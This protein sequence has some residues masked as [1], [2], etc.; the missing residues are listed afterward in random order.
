MPPS[1]PPA[2]AK[3]SD[4]PPPSITPLP[5]SSP[6]ST[7]PPAP[8]PK[9]EPPKQMAPVVVIPAPLPFQVATPEP[10][11]SPL[12]PTVSSE[13]P[14]L[15]A[16][17]LE[18]AAVEPASVPGLE[19]KIVDDEESDVEVQAHPFQ[20]RGLLG[21]LQ[22]MSE[23]I[24]PRILQKMLP[25]TRER[26]RHL[27]KYVKGVVAVCAAVCVLAGVS[28]AI[29]SSETGEAKAAPSRTVAI[30]MDQ[31]NGLARLDLV[32]AAPA[33]EAKAEKADKR[34]AAAAKP[35]KRR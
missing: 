18:V 12:A 35:A 27:A 2:V 31:R 34:V 17:P 22:T 28:A 1:P 21:T 14:M 19:R 7:P 30:L 25:A 16:P 33:P 24:D 13:T 8:A 20:R 6:L 23:V 9:S 26:R 32:K 11:P 3:A 29:G 10:T 4:A 5:I 15:A